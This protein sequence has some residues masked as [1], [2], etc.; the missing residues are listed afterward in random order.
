MVFHELLTYFRE[1]QNLNKTEL[2]NRLDV[3]STYIINME[4]GQQKPPS[5]DRCKEISKILNLNRAETQQLIDSAMS[6][7]M[8]NEMIAWLAMKQ[9]EKI[10]PTLLLLAKDPAIKEA[11]EDPKVVKVLQILAAS[12]KAKKQI[13]SCWRNWLKKFLPSA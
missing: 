11:L 6:E 4:A 1:R 9:E 12:K 3:S 7:R 8:S 5:L 13:V 2:A 10:N